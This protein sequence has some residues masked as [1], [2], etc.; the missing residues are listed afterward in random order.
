MRK[1]LLIIAM[2][3]IAAVLGGSCSKD[4]EQAKTPA[5][6][7]KQSPQGTGIEIDFDTT[8]TTDTMSLELV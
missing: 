1:K 6:E 5:R 3:G 7:S 8:S 2:M 4:E